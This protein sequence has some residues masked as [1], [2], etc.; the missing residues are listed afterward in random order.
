MRTFIAVDFPPDMLE[1]IGEICTFFK[2]KIPNNA[3]KWVET[4]NLHLT[5]K[6]LGE[7]NENKL[8]Q[9]KHTLTHALIG[10]KAF[11]V[12]VSG[13]GVYPNWAAPR[14][15]WLGITGGEPLI[16]IHSI[17]DKNLTSLDINSEGRPLS[18][19]L[20]IARVRKNI[21]QATLKKIS[22]T[23]AQFKVESLGSIIIDRVH[24]YKSVL[25][26]AGPSYT[27]LHSVPLNQV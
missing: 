13:L 3:L 5:I 2:Q 14:V 25:S 19:H 7:I 8:E 9:V 10:L 16:N 4:E 26:P 11:T 21:D 17:L 24:L 18:P 22:D 6:F 27:R 15:V 1:T 20:T 12:H 23:L